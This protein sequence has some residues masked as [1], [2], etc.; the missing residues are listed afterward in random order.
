MRAGTHR[1]AG[2]RDVASG[3]KGEAKDQDSQN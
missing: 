3:L 1:E 2:M